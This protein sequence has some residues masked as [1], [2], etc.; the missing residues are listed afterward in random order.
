MSGRI[1]NV[2]DV[3]A[4]LP[5]LPNAQANR[6]PERFYGAKKLPP[7]VQQV[8]DRLTDAANVMRKE[9]EVLRV[10]GYLTADDLRGL[11][12]FTDAELVTLNGLLAGNV[13]NRLTAGGL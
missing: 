10:L 1:E 12:V 7:E 6:L 11:A 8:I 4:D 2:G 13:L 5:A 9:M 3:P